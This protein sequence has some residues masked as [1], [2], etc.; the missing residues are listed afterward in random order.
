M[1]ISLYEGWPQTIFNFAKFFSEH[2][3]MPTRRGACGKWLVTSWQL[4]KFKI[5]LLCFYRFLFLRRTI[6]LH[7]ICKIYILKIW[8]PVSW[9]LCITQI[10]WAWQKDNHFISLACSLCY[11]RF[12]QKE[13]VVVE[14]FI[15]FCP[16]WKG[17]KHS[18]WLTAASKPQ[19]HSFGLSVF[20]GSFLCDTLLF[21]GAIAD[22]GLP[23]A[24][25]SSYIHFDT[26]T[27]VCCRFVLHKH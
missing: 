23:V 4:V 19:E 24:I 8:P 10:Y 1:Y 7:F 27:I 15:I 3:M 21:P 20:S 6:C 26:Q 22:T 17:I 9:W 18:C 11:Q 14:S 2:E 5:H 16:V 13:K 25:H 12:F